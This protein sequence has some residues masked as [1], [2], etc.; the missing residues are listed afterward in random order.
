MLF[1]KQTSNSYTKLIY[2]S[3]T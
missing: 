1:K 3:G 2:R